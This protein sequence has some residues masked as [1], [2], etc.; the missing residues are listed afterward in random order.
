MDV[1]LGRNKLNQSIGMERGGF[2]FQEVFLLFRNDPF[3]VIETSEAAA[4]A[5]TGNKFA[6]K[7]GNAFC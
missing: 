4:A 1:Q 6:I 2:L 3:E 7:P 5:A